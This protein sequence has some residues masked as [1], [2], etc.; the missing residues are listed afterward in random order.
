MKDFLPTFTFNFLMAQLFPG[1]VAVLCFTCAYM[2]WSFGDTRKVMLPTMMVLFS[3]VGELWFGTTRGVVLFLFLSAATGMFLHGLAWMVMGWQTQERDPAGMPVPNGS[4]ALR[5]LPFHQQPLWEQMLRAPSQ[6]VWEIWSLFRA[7]ALRWI[8]MEENV[9]EIEPDSMPNFTWLQDFYLHF[10]EFYVHMSY[11]LLIGFLPLVFTCAWL[12]LNLRRL[13]FILFLYFLMGLL[14]LMGRTQ[15]AS[16]FMNEAT[17][18][19]KAQAPKNPL[20]VRVEHK[21]LT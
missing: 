6:M 3:R 2:T 4:V 17:L 20:K 8:V 18:G 15:L 12:G 10:G 1:S 9:S 7:P 19:R 16:L 11:S 13:V 5:E 14:F 21:R